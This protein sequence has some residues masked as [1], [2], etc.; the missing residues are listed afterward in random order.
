MVLTFIST[1]AGCASTKNVGPEDPLQ[2]AS[3]LDAGTSLRAA[4]AD[5]AWPASTWWRAYND[6]QLDAWVARAQAGNPTLALAAARV[7]EARSMAGVAQAALAPQVDGS[8]AINRQQWPEN[9]Y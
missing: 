3:P 5:A 1:I 7:R 6:P 4:N 9:G 8:M 2:D